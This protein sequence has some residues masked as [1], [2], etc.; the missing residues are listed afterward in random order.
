MNGKIIKNAFVFILIILIFQCFSVTTVH[1][2][3]V[4]TIDLQIGTS[5]DPAQVTSSLQIL[6]LISVIALAPTL[7]IMVTCFPRILIALHFLRSAMGTQQMPPNQILIGIALFLTVFQ[8][9]GVFTRIYD[10]ALLPYS[11]GRMSQQVAFNVGMEPLRD[12][13]IAQV[14]DE[15]VALFFNLSGESVFEYP[16]VPTRILIPAFILGEI[17]KG[18]YAGFYIY[19]PFIIVDMVVA[20]VLMAMG[21]MMLPPAMISLPFKILIFLT[22]DGWSNF[23][24]AIMKGFR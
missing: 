4:P 6:L 11:E 2:I 8:M 1:A 14:E 22:A 20:S 3:S 19:V 24:S 15:D 23:I 17:R 7:L 18:F 13:M 12:F 9:G 10:E 16:E 21:M 5:N